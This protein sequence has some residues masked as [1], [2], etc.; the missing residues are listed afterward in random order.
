M[1]ALNATRPAALRHAMLQQ[2]AAIPGALALLLVSLSLS[3]SRPA[4]HLAS[5]AAG[6]L[7]RRLR[8]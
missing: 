3:L 8:S 1:R 7:P 2:P 5:G 6:S 4:A